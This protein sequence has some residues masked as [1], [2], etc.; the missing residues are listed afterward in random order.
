MGVVGVVEVMVVLVIVVHSVIV[1]LRM[2]GY[3]LMLNCESIGVDRM[4]KV[5]DGNG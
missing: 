1:R 2:C 4:R 5:F 3:L